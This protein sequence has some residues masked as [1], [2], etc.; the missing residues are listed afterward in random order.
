MAKIIGNTIATPYPRSNWEQTDETKPDYIKNKPNL[1]VKFDK[2]GGTIEGDVV[3]SG[4]L[5]VAG[6]TT[7]KDTETL[8]IKDNIIVANVD[9][10]ELINNAGFAIMTN[11]TSTYGIMYNP[12]NDGVMIGEGTIGEDGEFAYTE[13][14]A[15]YLATVDW[16][17]Q[18]G[19]IPK[20]DS[21][22]KTFVDSGEKIEEKANKTELLRIVRLVE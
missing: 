12:I 21:V 18:D 20:W 6:T 13:G 4:N 8:L 5:D 19:S 14:E 9:G 7:I 1:D 22:K 10:V 16:S 3:I 17:I 15:Q 2:T 11:E